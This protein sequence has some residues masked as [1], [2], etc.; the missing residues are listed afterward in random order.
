M[1]NDPPEQMIMK[2]EEIV[3]TMNE[4]RDNQNQNVQQPI[5]EVEPPIKLTSEN[6]LVWKMNDG[7][8]Y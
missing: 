5:E 3:V 7:S 6:G 4:R 1:S 2:Q 8:E